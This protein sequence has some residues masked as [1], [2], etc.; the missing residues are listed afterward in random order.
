LNIRIKIYREMKILEQLWAMR[1]SVGVNQ[2]EYT[3]PK[4]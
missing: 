2:H 1:A 4:K 3:N